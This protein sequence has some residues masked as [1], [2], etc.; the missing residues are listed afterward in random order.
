ANYSKN[1]NK[2]IRLTETMKSVVI[3][4]GDAVYL[5]RVDEGSSYGDVYVR[6]WARDNNGNRLVDDDGLPTLTNGTNVFVGNY[7]PDYMLG[8]SNSFTYK[9]LTLSFLI[10]HR[11]G[12]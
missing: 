2:V 12:G 10:D 7:N 8:F 6:G 11:Q 1:T 4:A 9:T 3:G 5:I